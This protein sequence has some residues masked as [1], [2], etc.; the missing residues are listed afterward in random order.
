M[1]GLEPQSAL[2]PSGVVVS[3][4]Q[5]AWVEMAAQELW[6]VCTSTPVGKSRSSVTSVAGADPLFRTTKESGCRCALTL[7]CPPVRYHSLC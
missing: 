2:G 1:E 5:A 3:I 6:L 7:T 4:D